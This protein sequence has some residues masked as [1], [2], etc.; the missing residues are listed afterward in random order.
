MV[1]SLKKLLLLG[2]GAAFVLMSFVGSLFVTDKTATTAKA[3]EEPAQYNYQSGTF[4]VYQNAYEGTIFAEYSALNLNAKKEARLYALMNPQYVYAEGGITAKNL[5]KS[6]SPSDYLVIDLHNLIAVAKSDIKVIVNG[7]AMAETA[8]YL[9]NQK[10]QVTSSTA[11]SIT[12]PVYK[13][14]KV[15]VNSGNVMS[16]KGQVVIPMSAFSGVTAINSVTVY[17][18]LAQTNIN[19]GKIGVASDFNAET[20][21]MTRTDIWTPA[22][23][24]FEIY[25]AGLNKEGNTYTIQDLLAVTYL[26]KGDII[27]T[28]AYAQGDITA[29][30]SKAS[31]NQFFWSFPD[32]MVNPEDGMVHLQDLGVKGLIFDYEAEQTLQL[33]I[34][35]GAGDNAKL[36]YVS[37]V[38]QTSNSKPNQRRILESGLIKTGNTS[39]MPSNF[40]GSVYIPFESASW[41]GSGWTTDPDVVY[42]VI[43]V[44]YNN[45]DLLN[46][47]VQAKITN[48]RF[49]TD[50]TAYKPNLITMSSA[51]GLLEGKVG[52]VAVGTDANN[53]VITGT[54]VDFT[55]S[56]NR[57]YVVKAVTYQFENEDEPRTAQLDANNK[58]SIIVTD[59]VA[60]SV[61]Y[62]LADYTVTYV[63]NGGTNHEENPET[64]T[65]L[66]GFELK[67]PT[68]PDAEFLG[69]YD[70]P[71]FKG[72]A[73]TEI[74]DG[75]DHNVTLYAKWKDLKA[76]KKSCKNA[77]GALVGILSLLGASL[78]VTFKR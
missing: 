25:S 27:F 65:F 62:Q 17:T 66:K 2:I 74:P 28:G 8:H 18:K 58:F 61:E 9:V 51:N 57:G 37:V 22:A 48:I 63:L 32:S 4:Y 24:N 77:A 12:L 46:Q 10:G 55:V 72:E 39:Y 19:V 31:R 3:A 50:D 54:R 34:R 68:K 35:L 70:N 23:D 5:N 73:I 64:F 76:P 33:A 47:K 67:A 78:V 44:D 26:N 7:T 36:D 56:P 11:A 60:V 49:I 30:S 15:T 42:P 16:F 38:Y 45:N 29:E 52:D 40:K 6:V 53:K 21:A 41:T 71:E 43:W 14:N 13:N 69:W 59:N 75:T 20:G 1:K